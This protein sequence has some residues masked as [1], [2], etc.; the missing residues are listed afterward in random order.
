MY[1]PPVK[2]SM[3][4]KKLRALQRKSSPTAITPEM[5]LPIIN[6]PFEDASFQSVYQRITREMRISII[7]EK[8]K[9][10]YSDG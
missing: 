9:E 5:P 6:K 3:M 8:K 1:K 7:P 2:A 4:A 10:R